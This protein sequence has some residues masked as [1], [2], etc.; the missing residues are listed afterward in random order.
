MKKLLL[1]LGLGLVS[2]GAGPAAEL[3]TR[4]VVLVTLDGVRWQEVFRGADAQCID[5]EHGGVSEKEQLLVRDEFLAG[6]AEASR[7]K[8]MPFFWSEIAGRGQLFGNRDTGSPAQVMNA[9]WFSYPGYNELLTGW[10]DP[11]INSN[12]PRPNRNVTVLEWLD[13]RPAMA[14]KVVAC[15]TWQIFPAILNAGR[16]KFPLWVSG[17][18]SRLPGLT[19][20]LQDI[21]RWM[22]DIPTKSRDEHYD[23]FAFHAALELLRLHQPRLLYLALGEADTNG[24]GRRYGKYLDAIRRSDRFIRELW[25][26][27]QT[28]PQYR[29]TTTMIITTDHGRGSTPADWIHHSKTV[30]GSEETWLAVLG[31]DTPALG[32][33]RAAALLRQTQVAATIAQFL[34]EDYLEA[35]PEAGGVIAEVFPA[36]P[37]GRG[38]AQP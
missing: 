15:V 14:G 24:H 5:L 4:N 33:R 1:C 34:G 36:T 23:G 6:D 28:L 32:E 35:V 37:A 10:V 12:L 13:A 20:R 3:K 2:A 8:L 29:G 38:P 17:G 30:P 26:H 19:P 21:E 27:L 16:S 31:P 18:H 25:E 11:M 9:E 22:Q 7:R